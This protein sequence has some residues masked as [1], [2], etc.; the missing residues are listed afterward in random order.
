MVLDHTHPSKVVKYQKVGANDLM[1]PEEQDARVMWF[2]RLR[3]DEELLLGNQER[4]KTPRRDEE[5]PGVVLI[6]TISLSGS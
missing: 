6:D 4:V 2:R 5:L 1:L 3:D